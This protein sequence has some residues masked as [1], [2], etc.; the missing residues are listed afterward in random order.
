MKIPSK[1]VRCTRNGSPSKSLS[2]V[3]FSVILLF[4]SSL[5]SAAPLLG[6]AL[7]SLA[8]RGKAGVTNVP[9][10]KI[11][12][13]LASAQNVR[14]SEEYTFVTFSSWYTLYRPDISSY[15]YTFVGPDEGGKMVSGENIPI[16]Q[17]TQL[18]ID[19]EITALNLSH[20][21]VDLSL[22]FPGPILPAT[23]FESIGVIHQ[24]VN[25]QS[26]TAVPEP[27]TLALLG[28]GLTGLGFARRRYR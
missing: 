8:I 22:D 24:A 2:V 21:S 10:S 23:G 15:Q 19:A 12:G 13:N 16:A 7:T 20:H 28:L 3:A 17:Q 4:C 11:S 6:L 14:I 25:I 26:V 1:Y 9:K 5:V 27:A 18:N